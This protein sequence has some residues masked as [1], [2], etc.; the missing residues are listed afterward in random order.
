MLS[1]HNLYKNSQKSANGGFAISE[2]ITWSFELY[3]LNFFIK[4]FFSGKDIL[5]MAQ[6]AHSKQK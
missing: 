2:N 1:T 5:S 3:E 6:C 4:E